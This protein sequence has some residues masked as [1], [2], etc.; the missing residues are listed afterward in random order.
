MNGDGLL[1]SKGEFVK[2]HANIKKLHADDQSVYAL[3][4][5][6]KVELMNPEDISVLASQTK[7][8][9]ISD[10]KFEIEAFAKCEGEI[11][12]GSSN[13]FVYILDDKTLLPKEGAVELKTN[14]GYPITTMSASPDKKSIAVGDSKGYITFFDVADKAQKGYSCH[15]KNRIV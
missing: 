13:G 5:D 11:W 6:G 9:M 12:V 3:Y 1:E 7:D 8:K 2:K 15:H 4:N 14:N 10:P